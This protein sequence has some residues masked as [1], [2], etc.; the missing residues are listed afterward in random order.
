MPCHRAG[1]DKHNMRTPAATQI[2]WITKRNERQVEKKG[3][4]KGIGIEAT[5]N[6]YP[7]KKS[8]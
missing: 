2:H 6:K 4:G 1:L 5:G 7:E 3:K 8:E